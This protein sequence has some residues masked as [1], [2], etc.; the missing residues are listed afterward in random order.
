MLTTTRSLLD[1]TVR[2]TRGAWQIL[3]AGELDAASGADLQGA[4]ADVI[5]AAPEVVDIDL[6]G[7][8]FVDT[9]GWRSVHE[10]RQQIIDAG[11]MPRI[12][13]MS[14]AVEQL[15]RRWIVI[16]RPAAA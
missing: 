9:A 10:A 15:V 16:G 12:V 3:V 4:T 5:A 13:A 2:R 6:T 14:P 7:V 1:I 8:T 11:G